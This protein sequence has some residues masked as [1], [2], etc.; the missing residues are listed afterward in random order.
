MMQA[1]R[2][3]RSVDALFPLLAV[4]LWGGN[5]V[6]AKAAA[7]L[8]GPI[9]ITFYRWLAAAMLMMPFAIGP[10]MR[11]HA[12]ST[13]DLWRLSVLGLLGSVMFPLLMYAAAHDTSAINI[14][15]IQTLMPLLALGFGQIIARGKVGCGT[16]VGIALSIIGVTVVVS[17]GNPLILLEIRPNQGDLL[18]LLAT[19]IFATYSVLVQYWRTNLPQVAEL[20]IQASAATVLLLPVFIWAGPQIP[21][22]DAVPLIGYAAVLGSFVAPLLWMQGIVRLGPARA[23]TFFNFLPV[24]TAILAV[25]LLGEPIRAAMLAGGILVVAGVAIAERSARG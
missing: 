6:V 14:G 16:L 3:T 25:G 15:I 20:F 19:I 17:R 18:M 13:G 9:E 22:D 11:Q 12:L 10:L 21:V 2:A 5:A 4:V 8:I 7:G 1:P 23:A 24:V